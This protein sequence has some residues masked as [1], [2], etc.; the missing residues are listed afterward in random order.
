MADDRYKKLM[1]AFWPK[2]VERKVKKTPKRIRKQQ[3]ASLKS[4]DEIDTMR[5]KALEVI[6]RYTGVRIHHA[7]FFATPPY[8]DQ[9]ELKDAVCVCY[10][11]QT[12]HWVVAFTA[13]G[14]VIFPFSNLLESALMATAVVS[15]QQLK[16][17][18]PHASCTVTPNPISE[19][20][21][22]QPQAGSNPQARRCNCGR[23]RE[24]R[25]SPR[26]RSPERG[27]EEG[28]R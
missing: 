18:G 26:P 6:E 12:G 16:Q 11:S 22:E 20:P 15:M 14:E 17:Q 25:Q 27:V 9:D 1:K 24:E 21:N 28:D 2:K 5:R 19:L 4:M 3:E 8:P 13:T 23:C 7:D 10:G